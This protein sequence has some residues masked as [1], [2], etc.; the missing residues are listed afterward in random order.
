MEDEQDSKVPTTSR[1]TI[2]HPQRCQDEGLYARSILG[3]LRTPFPPP[4]RHFPDSSICFFA[5]SSLVVAQIR[6]L[7][8]AFLKNLISI[9]P[10]TH[11]LH[12]VKSE[13]SQ[14]ASVF[15]PLPFISSTPPLA[16]WHLELEVLVIANPLPSLRTRGSRVPPGTPIPASPI[17]PASPAWP[18]QILQ[19]DR[20]W[21]AQ[22]LHPT[23]PQPHWFSCPI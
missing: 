3:T 1:K 18:A 12:S 2:S 22:L 21:P 14:Q 4:N 9:V 8:Q 19:P 15:P 11:P 17:P 6:I 16:L 13:L 23:R 10:C 5:I 7:N 20:P